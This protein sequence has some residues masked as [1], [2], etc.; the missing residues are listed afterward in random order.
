LL[1]ET[2]E[3]LALIVRPHTAALGVVA[4]HG[5]ARG[6]HRTGGGRGAPGALRDELRHRSVHTHPPSMPQ[7]DS[8]GAR[9]GVSDQ[10]T[11]FAPSV[12]W[13]NTLVRR[14]SH[15]PRTFD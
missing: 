2:A 8:Q 12:A 5:H 10:P 4:L 14:M 6:P 9:H 15:R 3:H 13:A 11:A 1:G 7:G